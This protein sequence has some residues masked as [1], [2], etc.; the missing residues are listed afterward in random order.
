MFSSVCLPISLNTGE[1]RA[2]RQDPT[3]PPTGAAYK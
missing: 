1:R 2:G 3:G